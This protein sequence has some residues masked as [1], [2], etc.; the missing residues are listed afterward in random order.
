MILVDTSAWIDFL[1][2]D[3]SEPKIILHQLVEEGED[4]C[5]AD[6]NVMEILQ[7]V[8]SEKDFKRLKKYLLEFPVFSLKS[9]QSY[10]EAARIYRTCWKKGV[11]IRK[12]IDCMI[13]R[14]AIEN[15]LT[16]L[17]KDTD[18]DNIAKVFKDLQ[19]FNS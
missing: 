18:F 6:I 13:A 1:K 3:N 4:I 15:G 10:I 2:P 8:R 14:V 7:G 17:H 11:T 19:I 16:L 9:S 12:S 5:L